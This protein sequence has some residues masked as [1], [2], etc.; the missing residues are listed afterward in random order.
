MGALASISTRFPGEKARL[1]KA[2]LSVVWPD[3]TIPLVRK[4]C[5]TKVSGENW[6]PS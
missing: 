4:G 5:C 2:E 1:V 3:W 6:T